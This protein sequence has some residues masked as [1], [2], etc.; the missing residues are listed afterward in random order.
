MAKIEEA[1][2]APAMVAKD[3]TM[4]DLRSALAAGWQDFRAYPQYGLFFASIYVVAGLFLYFALFTRGEIGWLVPAAAGFP[5]VAPFIAVGLYEVSRRREAGLPM[6]WPVILGS[7]RGRGDDQIISMGVI[8]FVAFAFWLMIAHG[9]FAIFLSTSGSG[10]ESLEFLQT[11]SGIMMLIVGTIVGAFLAIAFYAIT[12]ISLP[13]LVDRDVDFI[14]AIIVSLA[15]VRSNTFVMLAWAAIIA[16]TLF[17]AM[18]PAFLGLL[19]VSPVLAHGTWHLFRRSVSN[20]P[21]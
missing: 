3:L 15:V 21:Q 5:I 2:V 19:I 9:I 18:I 16:V 13:V 11:Q 8:V 20:A 14:T 17:V 1:P 4:A 7:L 6:S 12:V 10:S